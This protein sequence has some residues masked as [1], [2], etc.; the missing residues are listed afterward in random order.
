MFKTLLFLLVELSASV[1][2][3]TVETILALALTTTSFGLLI[4]LELLDVF[5]LQESEDNE[6]TKKTIKILTLFFI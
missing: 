3:A 6:N 2:L 1:L 5:S 4:F